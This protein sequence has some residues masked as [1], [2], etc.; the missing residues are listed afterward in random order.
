MAIDK[1][2][3]LAE[4]EAAYHALATGQSVAELRDHNGETI[5]YFSAQSGALRRYIL[6]LKTELGLLPRGAL[7]PARGWF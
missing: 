3:L 5:R 4:A 7:G 2:V 1:K 6:E